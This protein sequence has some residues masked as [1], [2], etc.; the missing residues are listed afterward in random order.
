MIM[1]PLMP[2]PERARAG[3]V[4]KA[5]MHYQDTP[6]DGNRCADCAAFVQGGTQQA[7]ASTCKLING[8]ISPDG[9][10]IAYSKR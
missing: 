8:P 5:A 2:V 6:K 10:C 9:W 3:S 7:G 4:S 1:I